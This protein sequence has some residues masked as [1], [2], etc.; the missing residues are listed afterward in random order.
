[1]YLSFRN[2]GRLSGASGTGG[3]LVISRGI[4]V[5]IPTYTP[6]NRIP[7]LANKSAPLPLNLFWYKSMPSFVTRH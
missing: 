3:I 1:M 4:G 6:T 7:L 2:A 5:F